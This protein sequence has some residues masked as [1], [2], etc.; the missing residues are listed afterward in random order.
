MELASLDA[1]SSLSSVYLSSS[2]Y[3][4]PS[5]DFNMFVVECSV[6]I[7]LQKFAICEANCYSFNV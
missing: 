6:P 4:V 3:R 7:D 5:Y 2:W 1:Y